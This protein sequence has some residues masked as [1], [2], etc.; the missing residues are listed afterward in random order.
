MTSFFQPQNTDF[1]VTETCPATRAS[2]DVPRVTAQL[3]PGDI[4]PDPSK[5]IPIENLDPD[6]RDLARRE[7]ISKGP[8]NSS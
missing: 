3:K 8:T 5:R 7:Y 1:V 6:I 4:E 2:D